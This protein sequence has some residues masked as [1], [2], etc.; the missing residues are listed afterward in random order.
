MKVAFYVD[1]SLEQ[2][3]LTPESDLERGVLEV[4]HDERRSVSVHRGGFFECRAGYVRESGTT[5][6]TMLVLRR[7]VPPVPL[8][9]LTTTAAD[10]TPRADARERDDALAEVQDRIFDMLLGDDGQAWQE[11]RKYLKRTRPDLVERLNRAK[12]LAPAAPD[13]D[14]IA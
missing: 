7:G 13:G 10:S 3:V 11:A 8:A 6:S 1:E 4:L 2:V 14:S 5:G 9:Q 12:P